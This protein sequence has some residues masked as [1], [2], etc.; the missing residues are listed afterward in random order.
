MLP[1]HAK[2][3][4][5]IQNRARSHLFPLNTKIFQRK[6]N[7]RFQIL[8]YFVLEEEAEVDAMAEEDD[9]AEQGW[10]PGS[11]VQPDKS[12]AYFPVET[13][14]TEPTAKTAWILRFSG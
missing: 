10:T 7:F 1:Y 5:N 11:P 9:G 2:Y 8:F 4:R 13:E 6:Q 3:Y 12:P 14:K